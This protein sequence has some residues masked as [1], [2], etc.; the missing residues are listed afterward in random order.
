[1]KSS[2]K[3]SSIIVLVMLFVLVGVL[4]GC[5]NNAP[6]ET[7]APPP[8]DT[9]E[10]APAAEAPAE[11][12]G[13]GTLKI[14]LLMGH[15]NNEFMQGISQYV[16]EAG[17]AAGA[18]VTVFSADSDTATQVSQLETAVNQGY[19]GILVDAVAAEGLIPAFQYAEDAGVPII[20]F[21]DNL[22]EGVATS[23]IGV[24][25]NQGGMIK[26]EQAAKDIDYAG[27]IAIMNGEM[28][29]SAQL[30]IRG[31]YDPIL[32]MY[33]DINIVFEDTGH[34]VAESAADLMDTWLASGKKLDS[35]VC[36]N[37]GMAVGVV[38]TLKAAGLEGTINVYGLD[39]QTEM[40]KFIS[41]GIANATILT[42]SKTEAYTGIDTILKL[43]RGETVPK[44]IMIDMIL[45]T[46]DNV[47]E[48][49]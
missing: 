31:G 38:N 20:A 34:W 41:E 1:M 46:K 32:E 7:T 4:A 19:D 12:S 3:R 39:A 18:E 22:T 25:F 30:T 47:D 40:L 6:A 9:T 23:F 24:N 33:P 5:S 37:D 2:F 36:N 35:V 44:E 21:H 49:M 10:S 17:E 11:P 16:V 14:A 27:D 8:A 45:I 29:S 43:I 13:D 48:F 28:G 15:V 42:D 26:M